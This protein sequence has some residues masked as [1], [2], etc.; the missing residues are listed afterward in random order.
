MRKRAIFAFVTSLLVASSAL[1]VGATPA[2][3]AITTWI[4]VKTPSGAIGPKV[5]DVANW[6]TRDRG[7]VHIWSLRTTGNVNNQ[8]W[9]I[10][11]IG[12][13]GTGVYQ[14]RNVNSGKCLD[15]S[16]DAPDANGTR[17][18]QYTCQTG[19]ITN[20]AWRFVRVEAGSNWGLLKNAS[21]GRC[22][23]VRGKSFTD[24]ALLQVWDCVGDWNQRFNI[25]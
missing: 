23:D 25:F 21:G 3:A 7:D 8:R 19:W 2:Q 20:Q 22:L 13:A 10:T 1:L 5:L 17:V 9:T 14:I 15:K 24:G 11:E 12:G 4:S 6:E 18:Y 16:L